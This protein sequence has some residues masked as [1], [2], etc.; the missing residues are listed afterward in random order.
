[1]N[2]PS[3]FFALYFISIF[4]VSCQFIPTP[5]YLQTSV[6]VNN[7]KWYIFG[8]DFGNSIYTNEIL[9]LDLSNS[10]DV[11]S[12]PWHKDQIG[13]S[14]KYSFSTSCVSVDNSSIFIIGGNMYDLD[15]RQEDPNY[16]SIIYEY[17]LNY[18][19]WTTPNI[20]G[21]DNFKEC[22]GLKSIIDNTGRIFLYG[23]VRNISGEIS[24]KMSIFYTS[25]MSW[26]SINLTTSRTG[27]TATLLK[28]GNITYIGGRSVATYNDSSYVNMNEI[29]IFDTNSLSWYNVTAITA[30][31]DYIEGRAGHSAVLARDSKI[32]I[33]GGAKTP[34]ARAVKPDLAMLDLNV[35]PFKWTILNNS[36]TL[37]TSHS[38]I[39]YDDFMI[40]VGDDAE[41]G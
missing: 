35:Y 36:L 38:A 24:N 32:L 9:Y 20:T 11:N 12:P 2:I 6:L 14:F 17:S 7:S 18:S 37:L 39:L 26:L 19:I 13:S 33:Y 29:L 16:Y 25:N 4:L 1:M 23:G 30:I 28:G 22:G 31:G 3:L 5:R 21:I 27:Y 34:K 10:F 8:G 15:Q 40:I 41:I